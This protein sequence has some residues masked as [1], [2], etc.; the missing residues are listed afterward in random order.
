MKRCNPYA[1]PELDVLL[2][3]GRVIERVPEVVRAR[4]LS[5]ARATM[6]AM[7]AFHTSRSQPCEGAA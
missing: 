7:A 2:E 6:A 5:R 1:D 4:S 3:A